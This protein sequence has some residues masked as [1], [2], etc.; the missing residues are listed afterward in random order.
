MRTK[1]IL[2]MLSA[3]AMMGCFA[4]CGSD[5]SSTADSS[6]SK[7]ESSAADT[8][9][10]AATEATTTAATTTTAAPPL[11]APDA[12]SITFDGTS[13]YTAEAVMDSGAAPIEMTI[14][15]VNGDK[16]LRVHVLKAEGKE[17]ADYEVP[18]IKF[19]LPALLGA[20]N[21]GKIGHISADFYCNALGTFTGEDGTEMLVVGNFLGAFGGNIAAMKAY[22]ADGD[23]I[24]NDWANHYEFAEN[25]WENPTHE[26]RIETD[27]PALL[28][29]NGYA[30][31][32]GEYYD[33]EGNKLEAADVCANQ[34][35]FIMR[36]GQSNE[37]DFYIDNLTFYDKDGKAMEIVYDASADTGASTEDGGDTTDAPAAET[38]AEETTTAAAA[39]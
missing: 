9:T 12:N 18:K 28:P 29:A 13:L 2:A 25:D 10:T 19:D 32:D 34:N 14:E 17:D 21:V 33:K 26:W 23:L 31:L 36:W 5:S 22:N 37:V 15:E 6:S 38:P 30:S 39:Q 7:E 3:L 20:E 16:K 11:E 8:T 24:Q 27:I 4:A 35:L 1:K